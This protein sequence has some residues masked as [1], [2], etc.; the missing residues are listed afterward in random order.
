MEES[1]MLMQLL[2]LFLTLVLLLTAC[3]NMEDTTAK[4]KQISAPNAIDYHPEKLATPNNQYGNREVLHDINQL[5]AA[6]EH[7]MTNMRYHQQLSNVVS[8]IEGIS[9]AW[10]VVANKRAYV[11]VILNATATGGLSAKQE[12]RQGTLEMPGKTGRVVQQ[13][14]RNDLRAPV[15]EVATPQNTQ[16]ALGDV[17]NELKLKISQKIGAA[18]RSIEEVYVSSHRGF[19]NRMSRY[20]IKSWKGQSLQPHVQEFARLVQKVMSISP[21]EVTLSTGSEVIRQGTDGQSGG[22]L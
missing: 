17:S 10:V 18:D 9:S 14:S 5:R 6:N 2:G 16:R 22:N 12:Y 20:A 15:G 21:R 4:N 19:I 7:F 1:V 8:G 3:A 11:A 13:F